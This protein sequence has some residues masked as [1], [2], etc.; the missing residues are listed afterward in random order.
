MQITKNSVK[1]NPGPSEWFTGSVYIDAVAVPSAPSRLSASSVH[2][3]PGARTA[4]HTHPNG[5]TIFVIEG[6][7][8]AQRRGGPIEVIRPGDR[9]FF[10]PG[11]HHWHGAAPNRFMTH[12]AMLDV[13]DQGNTATWGDHVSD[14][15]YS[16]APAIGEG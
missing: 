2:F 13:D 14:A 11:E 15:E 3:T 1:T 12:L 10:E 9:V 5:Q 4:W 16:A 8:L 6:V 7:G